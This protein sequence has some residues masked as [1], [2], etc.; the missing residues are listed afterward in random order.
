MRIK[1]GIR[2][3]SRIIIDKAAPEMNRQSFTEEA[4]K[5]HTFYF[6]EIW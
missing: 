2:D 6:D 4:I 3:N 5:L 1:R